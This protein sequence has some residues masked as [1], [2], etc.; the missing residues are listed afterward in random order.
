MC[1]LSRIRECTRNKSVDFD[2]KSR[3]FG[4][5]TSTFELNSA[6]VDV[7]ET[8]SSHA[9]LHRTHLIS[10]GSA[11]LTFLS[12]GTFVELNSAASDDVSEK[13]TLPSRSRRLLASNDSVNFGFLCR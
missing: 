11:T 6:I 9:R 5:I 4:I 13:A 8:A 12:P 7:G 1:R 2:R 10:F 3:G